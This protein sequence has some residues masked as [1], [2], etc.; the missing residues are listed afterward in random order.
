MSS[1]GRDDPS[2]CSPTRPPHRHSIQDEA[3]P[4]PVSYWP[5]S[6]MIDPGATAIDRWSPMS[7]PPI[8]RPNDPRH[9][10]KDLQV[11]CRSMP[12]A[13]MLRSLVAAV[14]G[15]LPSAGRTCVAS[16]TNW[17]TARRSPP[18]R[19]TILKSATVVL[20]SLLDENPR[21]NLG[22]NQHRLGRFDRFDHSRFA[23]ILR[24]VVDLTP[25]STVAVNG[26]PEPRLSS[27]SMNHG[28]GSASA[29][30]AMRCG[31]S[32]MPSKR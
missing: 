5:M 13:V 17:P 23:A 30:S 7:M 16:S 24:V 19:S 32:M 25:T 14:M 26:S 20:G 8:V 2:G 21:S 18:F 11:S 31:P 9:I 22:G 6:S 3:E 1:N 12:M 28:N 4:R 15:S 29:L 27:A 10:S